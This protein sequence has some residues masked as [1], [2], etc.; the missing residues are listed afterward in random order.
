MKMVAVNAIFIGE[1]EHAMR[2]TLTDS[3]NGKLNSSSI[4]QE[5]NS[6][7]YDMMKGGV[8]HKS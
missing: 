8:A 2:E 1:T 5:F 4:L 6:H 7:D 3:F